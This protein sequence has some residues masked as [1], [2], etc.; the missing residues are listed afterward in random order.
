[1][2]LAGEMAVYG[3]T[4]AFTNQLLVLGARTFHVLIIKSWSERLEHLIK[5]QKYPAAMQ[6]G[7]DDPGKGLVGLRGSRDRKRNLISLKMIGIL[8]RFLEISMTTNFPTEG[9]MGTLTKYFDEIVPPC[10]DL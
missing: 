5:N 4:T 9:G 6:L 8:R 7:A 2:S 1:M 3:S 10:V